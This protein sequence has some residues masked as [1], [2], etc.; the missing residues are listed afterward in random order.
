M[1]LTYAT[2]SARRGTYLLEVSKQPVPVPSRIAE[3]GPGVVVLSIATIPQHGID[4]RAAANAKTLRDGDVPIKKI[5]LRY[6][7]LLAD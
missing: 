4:Q 6:R 5:G 2:R 7:L 3:R 1:S